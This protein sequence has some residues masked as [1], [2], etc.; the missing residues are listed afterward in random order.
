MV[1]VLR[2][3]A[4]HARRNFDFKERCSRMIA[5]EKG[6]SEARL[7]DGQW[8]SKHYDDAI[9]EL[10]E[11]DKKPYRAD[12]FRNF[13]AID[14][15]SSRTAWYSAKSASGPVQFAPS[16]VIELL[17]EIDVVERVDETQVRV[18]K[19]PGFKATLEYITGVEEEKTE[20]EGTDVFSEAD[21]AE[22]AEIKSTLPDNVEVGTE[23][24][25]E[26]AAAFFVEYSRRPLNAVEGGDSEQQFRFGCPVYS[27]TATEALAE[28][29]AASA[30]K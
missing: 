24:T 1:R 10:K 11:E 3:A 16:A 30:T 13:P 28:H 17:T 22:L 4:A 19:E 29:Y 20:T 2:P 8:Y 9:N 27:G 18:V 14:F 12:V 23:L 5:E 7:E 26:K 25:V 15:A 6:L 21:A